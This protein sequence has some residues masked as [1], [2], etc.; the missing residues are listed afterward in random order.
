MLERIVPV[1][2]GHGEVEAI[3][4]LLRR[5]VGSHGVDIS[6]PFRLARTKMLDCPDFR[7]AVAVAALKAGPTGGVLIVL[8]A[9]DDLACELGPTLLNVPRAAARECPVGVVLAERE[10]EAWLLAS[11]VSLRQDRRVRADAQP[12]VDPQAIRDAKGYLSA[13][14]LRPDKPYSATVDQAGLTSRL[15]PALARR[16]SSFGKLERELERLLASR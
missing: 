11:A 5:L 15:D 16:C 13:N 4:V 2:E 1:V 12:P 8:D 6:R 7:N 9:D 10:Y 3:P 14:I